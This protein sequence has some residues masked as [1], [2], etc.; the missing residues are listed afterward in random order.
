MSW[1]ETG[2]DE[3]RAEVTRRDVNNDEILQVLYD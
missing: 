1:W 2:G 3:G